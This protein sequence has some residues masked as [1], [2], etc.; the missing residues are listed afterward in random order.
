MGPGEETD[1]VLI[2]PDGRMVSTCGTHLGHE[3]KEHDGSRYCIDLVCVAG[4]PKY[5]GK[6]AYEEQTLSDVQNNNQDHSGA[7]VGVL[8]TLLLLLLTGLAMYGY[9][10]NLNARLARSSSN[11]SEPAEG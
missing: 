4:D 5:N 9:R 3:F 6:V 10:K 11:S 1:D 7:L 2:E 8:V